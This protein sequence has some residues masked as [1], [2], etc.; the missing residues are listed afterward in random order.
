MTFQQYHNLIALAI[1]VIGIPTRV[2]V[3]S[4]TVS[5]IIFQIFLA[6]TQLTCCIESFFSTRQTGIQDSKPESSSDSPAS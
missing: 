6:A 2:S 3:Q 4:D 1:I 5:R